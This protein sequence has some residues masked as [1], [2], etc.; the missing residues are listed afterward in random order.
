MHFDTYENNKM[1]FN[2]RNWFKFAPLI[3]NSVLFKFSCIFK[4][5]IIYIIYCKINFLLCVYI[6]FTILYVKK[7][8]TT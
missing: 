1:L 8:F 4:N 6:D 5:I 7:V 3:F 2:L